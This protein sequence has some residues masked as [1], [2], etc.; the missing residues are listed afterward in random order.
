MIKLENDKHSIVIPTDDLVTVTRTNHIV[1]VQH[2]QRMNTT[3]HI[4]K[5]DKDRYVDL[6]TG[7]IKE[8]TRIENRSESINSLRQTFKKLRYLINNNFTGQANELF[9]TL[10]YRGDQ[11]TNDYKKVYVD[12]DKFIKRL[13][14]AYKD[15]STIDYI[16]VLE[17]H[18]SGNY[19]MHVLMRFNDL[20]NIYIPNADLESIWG[21][22]FVTVKALN[23]VDNIGAYLSAYLTDIELTDDTFADLICIKNGQA[24]I[25]GSGFKEVDGKRYIKGGRLHLYPPGVNLFRK[26]KG[27]MYPVR[28]RMKYGDV[29][30]IVGSAHPHYS[31]KI[32]VNDEEN[33]FKNTIIYEQYNIK[34][35]SKG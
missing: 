35:N 16:N 27:I 12:F 31:K 23:N 7:E 24:T 10:T 11:Q 1:E 32:D 8:F 21:H 33:D 14:Y 15:I 5:L 25:R 3:N 6:K 26:S 28:Q 9:I 17:P 19:H 30:K 13:R 18:A 22:G 34:R 4:K 2:M 29:K 20:D